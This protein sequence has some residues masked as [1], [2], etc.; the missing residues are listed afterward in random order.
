MNASFFCKARYIKVYTKCLMTHIKYMIIHILSKDEHFTCVCNN[1][2]SIIIWLNNGML[3][4]TS[5]AYVLQLHMHKNIHIYHECV[6]TYRIHVLN[7]CGQI[8]SLQYIYWTSLDSGLSLCFGHDHSPSAIPP[9]SPLSRCRPT[10]PVSVAWSG[11]LCG[12]A[13]R[14]PYSVHILK[15][16]AENKIKVS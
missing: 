16:G 4:C 5:T 14:H 9:C 12:I 6:Q 7:K 15:P 3:S 10:C 1:K 11:G 13:W 8:F 2:H